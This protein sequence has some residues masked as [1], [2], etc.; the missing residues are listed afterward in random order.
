MGQIFGKAR[1]QDDVKHFINIPN[2]TVIDLL[3]A[4]NLVAESFGLTLSEVKEM[5]RIS[6]RPDDSTRPIGVTNLQFEALV[7]SF[8]HVFDKEHGD[9]VDTFEF[10]STI[11]ISSD[12]PRQDKINLIFRLYDI[13][14]KDALSQNE[15]NLIIRACASGLCKISQL[16]YPTE[17]QLQIVASAAFEGVVSTISHH[18]QHPSGPTVGKK[19]FL[20]YALYI[21]EICSWLDHF[22]DIDIADSMKDHCKRL[23]SKSHLETN[24]YELLGASKI[25]PPADYE[26]WYPMVKFAEPDNL[27]SS[28]YD[29]MPNAYL[30][31]DWI[32][33]R[34]LGMHGGNNVAYIP[35][36][37]HIIYPAGAIGVVLTTTTIGETSQSYFKE[38]SH[39]IACLTTYTDTKGSTIVGTSEMGAPLPVIKIWDPETLETMKTMKGFHRNGIL[40][41]DFS[42]SGQLLLAMGMDSNHCIAIYKWSDSKILYTT[43]TTK[44]NVR[45]CRFLE[46]DFCFGICGESFVHIWEADTSKSSFFKRRRCLFDG[47]VSTQTMTALTCI[48]GTIISGGVNGVLYAWEG[49]FNSFKK[50][51]GTQGSITCIHVVRNSPTTEAICVTTSDG[52]IFL[53]NERLESLKTHTVYSYG[54]ISKCIDVVS[55]DRKDNRL[56]VGLSSSELFEVDSLSG[57]MLRKITCGHSGGSLCGLHTNPQLEDEVAT[58]GLDGVLR[59]WNTRSRSLTKMKDIGTPGNCIAYN[60]TA[61]FLA[62]GLRPSTSPKMN[63]DEKS[64]SFVIL[65]ADNLSVKYYGENKNVSFLDCKY[66]NDDNLLAFSSQDKSIYIYCAKKYS[67][68]SRA[69]GHTGPIDHIDFGFK[70]GSHKSS[71]LQSNSTN[72]EVMFWDINGKSKTP[73]SQRNIAYESRTCPLD[74]AL[75]SAGSRAK[76]TACDNNKSRDVVVLADVAGKIRLHKYPIISR[77]SSLSVELSGHGGKIGNIRFSKNDNFLYSIG[78]FDCCLMQW[79]YVLSNRS[80]RNKMALVFGEQPAVKEDNKRDIEGFDQSFYDVRESVISKVNPMT[81]NNLLEKG[82]NLNEEE[83]RSEEKENIE[84]TTQFSA[85]KPWERNVVAPTNDVNAN[86]NK[87]FPHQKLVPKW[88]QGYDSSKQGI[89]FTEGNLLYFVGRYLISYDPRQHRQW[90]Y[91]ASAEVTCMVMHPKNTECAMGSSSCPNICCVNT[92]SMVHMRDIKLD[93]HYSV[94]HL[95]FDISGKRLISLEGDLTASLTLIDWD[96]GLKIAKSQTTHLCTNGISFISNDKGIIQY[97]DEFLRFWDLNGNSIVPKTA[98]TG[99]RNRVSQTSQFTFIPF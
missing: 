31:L 41:M 30:D 23:P 63:E 42:S 78:E 71:V 28:K 45:D 16:V 24:D 83:G 9:V 52:K 75:K 69:K 97:G 40:L 79:K 36:T 81:Y 53:M 37:G 62:V 51:L 12:T 95:A 19:D 57:K 60:S 67:L 72:G 70:A 32:Y 22:E 86:G 43:Q 48:N 11:I 58:V 3:E 55:W 35:S 27:Q 14:E 96:S 4:S 99:L 2:K 46:S 98:L 26:T 56:L 7:E 90:F 87:D 5:F 73:R 13:E 93:H 54:N 94:R 29:E 80:Q 50:V 77:C 15:V 8:Y 68:M 89:S 47:R 25:P 44:E 88:I 17:S 91:Q 82:K 39:Y 6:M 85:V 59:L 33:G 10:L 84:D 65:A 64:P 61:H 92:S 76:I 1:I 18:N 20:E 66:S 74:W 38:H 34:N 49:R 21:P